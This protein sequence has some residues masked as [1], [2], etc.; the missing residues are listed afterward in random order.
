MFTNWRLSISVT[1]T[2]CGPDLYFQCQ[3]VPRKLIV[4][5][6]IR[7]KKRV[8]IRQKHFHISVF[9]NNKITLSKIYIHY[10]LNYQCFI[11]SYHSVVV[12]KMR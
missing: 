4:L 12:I 7:K 2:V 6:P 10:S 1:H 11:T 3:T 9:N 8:V 5:I